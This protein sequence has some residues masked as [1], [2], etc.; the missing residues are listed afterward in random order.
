MYHIPAEFGPGKYTQLLREEWLK[1]NIDPGFFTKVYRE[2]ALV[3]PFNQSFP[4][5]AYDIE[6]P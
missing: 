2:Y 6:K 4:F 1:D 5:L 3:I